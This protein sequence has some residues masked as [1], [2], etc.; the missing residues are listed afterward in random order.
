M[1]KIFLNALAASAG[2]GVTYV[3]NVLPQLAKRT[4]VS[5]CVA[6]PPA[7]RRELGTWANVE[8]LECDVPSSAFRR[9]VFEQRNLPELIRARGADVLIS[10]GNFALWNSPV[11]QILLSRNSLYTSAVF[12]RDVKSRRHYGL[13]LDTR[14][15]GILAAASVRRAEITVAPSVAFADDVRKWTGMQ[16]SGRILAIHHGFDAEAFRGSSQPLSSEFEARLAKPAHA[17]RLLFVSHYNYYR[18]FETLLRAL[19]IM[20]DRLSE[21]RVELLLTCKLE[22]PEHSGAYRAHS[23]AALSDRLGIRSNVIELGAVPYAS[24][25][26]VYRS[27]DVYVTPAYAETFAHPLVEAMSSGLPIVASDLPVH[28]EIC[29][30]AALYFPYSSSEELAQQVVTLARDSVLRQSMVDHAQR[31]ATDFS[32]GRH[33]A[34]LLRVARR[35]V[36]QSAA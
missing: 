13:W 19:A 2:G 11:P 32:W 30:A 4:D 23:A 20:R 12:A 34:E 7:L 6:V 33:V 24:L 9:V 35:L 21:R 22:A 18:N 29:G 14:L 16:A 36:E 15:K 27:S 28:H 26:R 25:H 5:V 1:M 31:R 3:R 17:L 10:A 8:L